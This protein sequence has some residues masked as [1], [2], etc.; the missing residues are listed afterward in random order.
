M[1]IL[2]EIIEVKKE[3]VKKLR[4]DF[5]ISRFTDSEFFSKKCLDFFEAVSKPS[6]LN[7]IAEIKKA[8]PSKGIIRESFNHLEIA[9]IYMNT[10]V[11]AISV[12]TDRNFF[13]GNLSYLYDI[14]KIKS[15]PVLRKEFIIDEF[16]I[17]EA[18]ANGADAILLIAEVLSENQIKELTHCAYE[19]GLQ[20]LLELHEEEEIYKIDFSLNKIAGI[21]NRDLKTFKV[22]LKTTGLLGKNIPE[23]VV[24][25]SESGIS[26]QD[27]IKYLKDTRTNAILVG[28][29]LMKQKKIADSLKILI[30]W[31]AGEN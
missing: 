7:I 18:K 15:V 9:D 24:L 10:G 25:V 16:Q 17:Y 5:T 14:A 12:L 3:E 27:D 28:E 11:D 29:H 13:K 26:K 30:E 19:L 1:T 22:D 23:G 6:K 31:C 8:S 20:V 21:N 4:T 2:E